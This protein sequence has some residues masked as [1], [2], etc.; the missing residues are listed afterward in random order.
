MGMDEVAGR[1]SNA[2]GLTPS[3]L[4]GVCDTGFSEWVT[5]QNNIGG[6]RNMKSILAGIWGG[7]L[8]YAGSQF[9]F[10]GDWAMLALCVAL[11]AIVFYLLLW[12][13]QLRFPK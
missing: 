1:E 13:I 4:A 9:A 5:A 8:G 3:P 12:M 11:I 7:S 6:E 10:K 2:P